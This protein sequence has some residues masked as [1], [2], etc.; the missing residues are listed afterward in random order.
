MEAAWFKRVFLLA[1]VWI[2]PV[3]AEVNGMY[4]DIV[5]KRCERHIDDQT[6]GAS[7]LHCPGVAGYRLHVSED[8]D[9]FSITVLAAEKR[10]YDLNLWEVITRGFFTLGQRVEWRVKTGSGKRI[11]VALI[12]PIYTS[13]Q[14]AANGTPPMHYLAVV[15]IRSD[16]ACVVAK[17]S[18]GTL[19]ADKKA[20][21]IADGAA[22]PCLAAATRDYPAT[23]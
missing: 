5:G 12:V 17:I 4:T 6:T 20:R 19:L 21:E 7:T 13:D 1:L 16:T 8:D 15:H 18:G 23:E 14:S 22:L 11:P 9:R 3:H 10:S 2:G